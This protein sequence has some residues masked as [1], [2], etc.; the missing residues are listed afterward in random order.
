MPCVTVGVERLRTF[1]AQWPWVSNIGLNLKPFTSNGDVK[2]QTNQQTIRVR[3]KQNYTNVIP[4]QEIDNRHNL[5]RFTNEATTVCFCPTP[6]CSAPPPTAPHLTCFGEDDY[7]VEA[8]LRL[9]HNSSMSDLSI[10]GNKDQHQL[11]VLVWGISPGFLWVVDSDPHPLAHLNLHIWDKRQRIYSQ[12][13]ES[14]W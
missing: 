5:L 2:P 14:M 11:L 12:R 13:K 1:T 9:K 4:I 10:D 6:D 8:P 3:C 7:W